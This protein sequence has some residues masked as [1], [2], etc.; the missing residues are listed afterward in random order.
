MRPNRSTR[1]SAL[2]TALIA[3]PLALCAAPA[4]AVTGG[5]A[6]TGTTHAYTA[7][8]TVGDHARGCSGTLVDA[9]W[10]L[11]AASCF[12]DDPAAGLDVAAGVPRQK[13]TAVIGRA[14]LTDAQG[15]ERRIVE[16]VPRADRDVVLARLNRPVTGVAP[17]ALATAAPAAGE[18]LTFAGY[19][20]TKDEWAPLKLH[21]GAYTVDSAAATTA[22]VTG[23]DGA[24]ACRG[25]AGG[26]V[27]RV[28]NGTATLV[29]LNSRSFQGGCFGVDD[30]VTSTAGIAARVDDL[31]SWVN[32]KTGATR[33]TD[34]NGD[35][36]EDIAI[37]DPKAA[38]GGDSGAGAV[39]VVYGG[40]EGTAEIHQD[41]SW[42]PGGAE[43]DDWFG[44]SL[45]TVDYN[46]DGYTDLVVGTPSEDI[47]SK[48]DV[49]VVTVFYGARDGIG[50]GPV[51][52]KHFI[53]GKGTGS[54]AASASEAGDRMGQSLAAGTTAAG[55]PWI[56]AGVPGEAVGSADKAGLAFYIHGDTSATLHQDKPNVPGVVEA[57]DAF[58]FSV[59]GDAHHIAIG[60]PDE[61]IGSDAKSGAVAVFS[62]KLDANGRPTVVAGFDQDHKNISG[63]AE[64]GDRFGAA[65]AMAAYRP[66]GSAT[67]DASMLV[68]GSP[69]E[70]VTANGTNRA[71][72]GR[73]V[74][75]RVNADDSTWDYLHELNPRDSDD[76]VAGTAEAGDHF[77]E[78]VSIVN[79]APRETGSTATMRIAVGAPGEDVGSTVDAGVIQTF[80]PFGPQGA[81]DLWIQAGD[82]D[83]VPGT[84]GAKQYLGKSI[85][86]TG[87]KLYAGMAYG[88]SSY[89]ALHALPMGNLVPGGVNGPT[90][91]YE[92]GKGGLPASG[93]RFGYAAR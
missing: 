84:P 41:L 53:Q 56:L 6:A 30:T 88:P 26:P 48:K 31:A 14:D 40:G 57:G 93:G 25:D 10:L 67:A 9:E 43:V 59:A 16:L 21:T 15:A 92:P 72:A 42:V 17:I 61:A 34:F 23:Q 50:T 78:A 82:G 18:R 5:G 80:S 52:N 77:G 47:G 28:N 60:A 62:H 22:A 7:E 27:V 36:V 68:I 4:S 76:D 2:A 45:A 74:L 85:H 19:G 54:I 91:T 71:G 35:G 55:R 87:T 8:I 79:T 64:P 49:G 51:K 24:A 69:G 83:G 13:T 81:N 90:T 89:G 73:A 46:E 33:I 29:A 3:G 38:V 1:L 11:T 66:S 65:V 70:G 63:G 20:R 75:V 32:A 12:V 58:G 39:R 37:A 44:E 86:L